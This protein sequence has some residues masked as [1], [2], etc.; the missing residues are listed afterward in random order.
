MKSTENENATVI[1]ISNPTNEDIRIRGNYI[2]TTKEDKRN[3]GLGI[4]NIRRAVQKYNG[5]ADISCENKIFTI[6]IGL[7]L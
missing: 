3:H 4:S 7:I 5:Y 2:K 1:T 6:E